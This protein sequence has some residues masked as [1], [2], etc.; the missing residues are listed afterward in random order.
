MG[1]M[2]AQKGQNT[3]EGQALPKGC[4]VSAGQQQRYACPMKRFS[5]WVNYLREHSA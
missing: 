2:M 4:G 1:G 3:G 5:A